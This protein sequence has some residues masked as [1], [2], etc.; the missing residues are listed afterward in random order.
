M[1]I[2]LAKALARGEKAI[3]RP[4]GQME[5]TLYHG[6]GGLTLRYGGR[7]VARTHASRAGHRLAPYVALALGAEIPTLGQAAK[8]V[9][10][11][12]VLFRVLSIS[13]LDLRKEEAWVM[14]EYLLQEAER[15]RGYASALLE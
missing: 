15:M 2:S 10:S 9:V 1:S 8:A 3:E 11:S 6:K 4:K 12:G 5:I 7:V 14:L 13:S